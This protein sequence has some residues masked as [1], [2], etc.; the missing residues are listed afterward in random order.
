MASKNKLVRFK[1]IEVEDVFDKE[2][3]L[4]KQVQS[5]VLSQ[6]LMLWQSKSATLVL[7]SGKKWKTSA[8]LENGLGD[9]GWRLISRKTGGAPVPQ[10]P[11]IINLSHIYHWNEDSPYDIQISYQ[12]LCLV[13]TKF[14]ESLG[15]KTEIHA[16]P[17]S[18]CDGDYNLNVN[19]RKIVGTAQRVLLKKDGGRVVLSQACILIDAVMDEIVQPVNLC[20]QL[21]GHSDKIEAGVHTSLF[22]HLESNSNTDT[23][24]QRLTEAFLNYG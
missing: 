2:S 13:L 5:G 22:E 19:G 11:G 6:V 14:F 3:E 12:K 10:I 20:N 18:Y 21:C 1:S 17:G 8:E 16:T 9:L 7:P 4:L 23:L 15:V 24:F